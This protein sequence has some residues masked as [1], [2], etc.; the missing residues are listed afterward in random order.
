[1]A[2]DN[3]L[4]ANR[5]GTRQYLGENSRGATVKIGMGE[6]EFTPGELF[7]LALATCQ[8]LSSDHALASKLGADFDATVTV[9]SEKHES[10]ERYTQID[11]QIILDLSALDENELTK[12]MERV[13]ASI[14]KH[15]TIG[16]SLKNGVPYT[17]VFENE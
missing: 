3:L 15:C 5:T 12:L 8:T 11:S 6:G 16:H 1:M 10:E 14:E 2:N 4:W 9:T 7:K 17:Y 13:D